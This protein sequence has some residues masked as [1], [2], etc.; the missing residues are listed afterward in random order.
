M[1]FRGNPETEKQR[2]PQCHG[3]SNLADA[4]AIY[5]A[6]LCWDCRE[7]VWPALQAIEDECR[8]E[9]AAKVKHAIRAWA[10]ARKAKAA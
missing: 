6:E 9:R 10:V 1:S 2:G 3:C 7:A 5:D 8:K 4:G